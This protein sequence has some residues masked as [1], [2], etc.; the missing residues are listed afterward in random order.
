MWGNHANMER[1]RFQGLR[2]FSPFSAARSSVAALEWLI[3]HAAPLASGGVIKLQRATTS[4]T[5][6][7]AD[8]R[9]IAAAGRG[10][11]PSL[12]T[13]HLQTCQAMCGALNCHFRQCCRAER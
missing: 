13:S 3:D 1:A 11:S 6:L 9:R 2:L 8:A 5:A 10:S 7:F 12:C 4:A